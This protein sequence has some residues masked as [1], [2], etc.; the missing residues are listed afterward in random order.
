MTGIVKIVNIEEKGSANTYTISVKAHIEEDTVINPAIW[1]EYVEGPSNSIIVN[2][3]EVTSETPYIVTYGGSKSPCTYINDEFRIALPRGKYGKY[4]INIVTGYVQYSEV[5]IPTQ[6][7][8]RLV[9]TDSKQIVLNYEKPSTSTR[10]STTPS[11]SPSPSQSSPEMKIENIVSTS[12]GNMINLTVNVHVTSG[13]VTRPYIAI[14]YLD[15]PSSTVTINGSSISREAPY[16][17][18]FKILGYGPYSKCSRLSQAFNIVLPYDEYGTYLFKVET[19]Y[20]ILTQSPEYPEQPFQLIPLD[21]KL[22]KITYRPSTTSP[23]PPSSPS[24]PPP[25]Y[26]PPSISPP[27][28]ASPPPSPSMMLPSSSPYVPPTSPITYHK[29]HH[30]HISPIMIG[31]ALAI[32][33]IMLLLASKRR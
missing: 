24:A 30:L 6:P 17:F 1:V 2:G 26:A 25:S 9:P 3:R 7:P 4:I 33:G 21:T 22:I 14:Y 23:T 27:P 19:G 11:I 29:E 13:Q 15:G 31:S 20:A 16:N 5:R 28:S 32:F 18:V 10:P 12:H 8:F